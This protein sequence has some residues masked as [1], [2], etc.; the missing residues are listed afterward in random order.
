VLDGAHLRGVLCADRDAP[1]DE[2][3]AALVVRA[4]EQVMH[5][6]HA[7][8]VF[9]ALERSKYEHERF[10]HASAMLGRAL[11]LDQVVETAFGAAGEIVDYDLGVIT[12][13]AKDTAR[14][15]V[16]SVRVNPSAVPM[17]DAE[18]L[19]GLEFRD[20]A[21]LVSMVVKNRHYLP[22][23]GE[24]RDDS[25]PLFTRRVKLKG[26]ESLVVLPLTS[27]DEAIGTLSLLA[28]ARGR[29]RK[30]TREMLGVIANQVAISLQN[31]LM[32]KKMETMATTDG[33]T[34]LTNHRSFQE[35]FGQLLE[36]AARHNHKAAMLLCDVDHFKKVNDTYGH[37]VG[38]EV[39]RRVAR[40]LQDAVRKIDIPARYGGE[41][42]AVVLEATDLEGALHLAD[43][44]RAD[45]GA[46]EIDSDKGKLQVTMSIG[47]AAFPDDHREQATLIERA[48]LALYHAKQTGR[49]RVVA[50]R[51]FAADKQKKAS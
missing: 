8:Q 7:E 41:E 51:D 34:G 28:R 18:E 29:F 40:V 3:D 13:F 1:F 16:Q 45:V 15:R 30:D 47:V 37:P 33:L 2:R 19:A 32:Y 20:N 14:H 24:L 50:Y 27:A 5:T 38:D 39:L 36:R 6:V 48:D 46:L 44:I 22:A 26:C 31:A 43:R 25:V 10:Y 49:N 21:S 17:I 35:R 9:G 23:S 42:F 12:L 4:A 11:T